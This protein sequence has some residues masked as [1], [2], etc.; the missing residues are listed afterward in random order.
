MV[1]GRQRR[2]CGA[3]GSRLQPADEGQTEAG[4]RPQS[5]R[6][7]PRR[8][9][10]RAGLGRAGNHRSKD[11]R[12][13]DPPNRLPRPRS[14]SCAHQWRCPPPPGAQGAWPGPHIKRG[15]A[16]RAS[17]LWDLLSCRVLGCLA[18]QHFGSMA[19]NSLEREE[20]THWSTIRQHGTAQ[21]LGCTLAPL[22]QGSRADL[23]ARWLRLV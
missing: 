10:D 12:L 7:R 3:R 20:P 2:A 22:S 13:G 16:A 19:P 6:S 23:K 4:R 9:A 17:F 5:V 15:E 1:P 18:G 14:V 21:L 11:Q 8:C